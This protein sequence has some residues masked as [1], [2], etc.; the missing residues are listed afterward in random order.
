[1]NIIYASLGHCCK[2]V[3]WSTTRRH[4]CLY[5]GHWK[6]RLADHVILIPLCYT[7]KIKVVHTWLLSVGFRSWSG[8]WQSACRWRESWT[9][10]RLPLLFARP[11]VTLAILK[12]A[13]TSFTASWTEAQWVWTVCLRCYP[14]ASWLRFEPRP[15]C[16]WVQ[17]ADHSATEP[18]LVYKSWLICESWLL[19]LV[20]P[21]AVDASSSAQINW[22][23]PLF[24]LSQ[25]LGR[26]LEGFVHETAV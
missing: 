6:A 7:K 20:S 1:V 2:H 26:G 25:H 10:R 9:R 17:H 4:H 22:Q 12:R 11:A 3:H 24:H 23:T 15:F 16:A 8:S 14:T 19:T 5:Y 13:A 18:S 21:W